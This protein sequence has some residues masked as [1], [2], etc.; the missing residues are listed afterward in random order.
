[1]SMKYSVFLYLEV[2]DLTR[3]SARHARY[4]VL[5]DET[6]NV[7]QLV[8]ILQIDGTRGEFLYDNSCA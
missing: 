2:F 6:R 5:C 3:I 4:E 8:Q 7:G 1:M